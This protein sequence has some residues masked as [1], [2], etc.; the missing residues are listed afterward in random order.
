MNNIEEFPTHEFMGIKP[1]LKKHQKELE[2]YRKDL[3]ITTKEEDFVLKCILSFDWGKL[4]YLGR[5][6]KIKFENSSIR[7]RVY[8]RVPTR[9]V[10]YSCSSPFEEEGWLLDTFEERARHVYWQLRRYIV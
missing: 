5:I 1:R 7:F 4:I 8:V 10:D 3:E 6:E 2:K 9:T